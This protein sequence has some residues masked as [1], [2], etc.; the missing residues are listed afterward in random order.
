M[1]VLINKDTKVICQGFTG[2]QGTFHSE[3]A[4]EYGTQMV[5]GVSPGKGG[6]THLGLPVFN[7]VRDA[8]K[9]TGATASVIYV[10]APFCKDA[11]LEA[12]DAGIEL[13]VCITEGIPTL[14]MVDVKVK[15]DNSG[16][17]MIGPNCPGVITPG[18]TKIGIMPGHIHKPG[19]VGIVSR[20]GTLTYEAVKQTTDAGFGQSTCVG[21]GGDPIP[22]TNFIDVLEMFEKDPQT[23]A[24]VMIGE[25]GGTAEEEAAE[26]IKANV[27]KPVVS[28]I[29][30]VTAPEGKRM[31]HAGAIIAGGKGTADE[32]FAALE[33]A[34]VQTVRSLADIGKALK[35]KTGW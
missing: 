32:K 14:D 33:A 16:V 5:G 3:Q 23:E 8:V 35:E 15:L 6:Q 13:I 25:I 22:G 21:I 29:A 10:P 28:Y 11:I 18:E 31:G 12:I 20:S 9:E 4:L 17:R 30:G 19:K 26:Y 7:T 34:G 2:G 1:S 27:T 24:I